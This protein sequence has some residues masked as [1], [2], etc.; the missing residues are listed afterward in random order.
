MARGHFSH[1]GRPGIKGGSLPGNSGKLGMQKNPDVM[2]SS[3]S[4]PITSIA[5]TGSADSEAGG[6]QEE[7]QDQVAVDT[8][9]ANLRKA[10]Q[11]GDAA[12]IATAKKALDDAQ[13]ELKDEP[14]SP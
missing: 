7:Q 10:R 13:S 1:A 5:K 2:M 3:S 6:K 11:S 14:V 9:K 4:P 12:K 8:A